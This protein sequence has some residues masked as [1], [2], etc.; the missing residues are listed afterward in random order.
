M[1]FK[2]LGLVLTGVAAF[3]PTDVLVRLWEMLLP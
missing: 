2:G 3:V 1:L